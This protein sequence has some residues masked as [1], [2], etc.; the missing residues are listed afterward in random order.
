MEWIDRL[1]GGYVANLLQYEFVSRDAE[2]AASG[3][4]YG[5]RTTRLWH[6]RQLSLRLPRG[7]LR[8]SIV[9][10]VRGN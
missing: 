8:L 4:E 3:V 10:A 7:S 6:R 1:V 5:Y 2:H 9:R